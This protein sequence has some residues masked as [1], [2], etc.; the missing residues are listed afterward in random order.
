MRTAEAIK[1]HWCLVFVAYSFLHLECL[2][3]S[4]P[5]KHTSPQQSIGEAARQQA[6]AL[7]QD[8]ILHTHQALLNG[9]SIHDLVASLFAKQQPP[10]P[11]PV[12]CQV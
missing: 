9:Q 1:K 7:I 6:Q 3:A 5:K 12:L 8:L 4:L 10:I 11:K 2:S